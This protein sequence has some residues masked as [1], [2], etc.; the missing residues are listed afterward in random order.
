MQRAFL[1]SLALGAALA[2][3]AMAQSADQVVQRDADAALQAC[4]DEGGTR[5]QCLRVVSTDRLE[6]VEVFGDRPLDGAGSTSLLLPGVIEDI[7]PDHPAELLNTLPGVNIHINSGQEHLLAIR[8]PVLT[9]GAGQGSFLVLENGVPTRSPAFGNVNI[10]LEPHFETAEYIE[11]VRGPG[12]AKHGS[13]AVHGLVNVLL[14][15]PEE[16]SASRHLSVSSLGRYKSD[17]VLDQ[18]YLARAG[19]S[20]QK[21]NGWRDNTGGLQIKGSGVAETV[22]G[23]WAITAWGSASHLEQ[24]TADFI[25]GPDAYKDRDLAKT[26]DDPLAYRD[27]WS[28]RGAARFERDFADGRLALTPFARVQQM[29]FRQH[30]LPYR[31]FEKN[32]HTGGGLMVR[33]DRSLSD[34]LDVRVGV[35]TDIASGYLRE[36][37]PEPFGF[38]PGDTRFPV[39]VHYDYSVDTLMGALWVEADW[40]VSER[41]TVLAGLRGEAHEYDYTTEATV[42]INGRFNVPDDRTDTFDFV[43]P[44][45]GLVYDLNETIDLYANLSRG[46]RAPQAS[47]LYRLQSQ[48]VVGEIDVET[49]DSLEIGAR[50]VLADGDL[51]FDVAAYAMEKDNF[52]FRDSDGLNVP[53]GATE[54]KGIEAALDWRVSDQVT[55]RGNVAWSDQTYAFDRVVGNTA[56]VIRDGDQ[57]DTA[58][59]WLADLA[60]IWTPTAA[61]ELGLSADY[62]GEYYTNPAN[63][64]DYPGHTVLNLRGA[65]QFSPSLETYVTVRNLLDEAYADRADFAFGNERYFPGEPLNVTIG[66][67]STF[68]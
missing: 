46:A 68:R 5:I 65:Y 41:L 7:A 9:G 56:E 16:R 27:A 24:E 30:F 35:D 13:N 31:G 29:D 64:Q 61:L 11:V 1:G 42:G 20:I 28:A 18:G 59:E 60:V 32:G 49:L 4:F 52:F 50:G 12:S 8:S 15:D 53:D 19:L 43:A 21:D 37:Q 40:Q 55:V 6:A 34:T 48:Q 10:L 17:L 22:L 23:G 67:R 66:V 45:L 47:D 57:I 44:K 63:T 14:A 38:F 62:V 54:H 25:E 33:Y 58:P 26:N 2:P 51:V 3:M 36:T 39:G